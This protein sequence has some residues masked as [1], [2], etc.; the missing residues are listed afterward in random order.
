VVIQRSSSTQTVRLI[1]D[2]LGDDA[3]CREAAVARLAIVGDRAVDRLLAALPDAPAPGRVAILRVLEAIASPR[4]LPAITP[5]LAAHDDAVAVAAAGAMR[6]HLKADDDR[7]ATSALEALTDLVLAA[8][9]S[10]PPRLAALDALSEMDAD[11]LRPIRDRLRVD[12]SP[13]VRRLA[14]WT[15]ADEP[16]AENAAARLEAAARGELPDDGE[17]LRALVASAGAAVA[18]ST[19]LDLVKTLRAREQ[20]TADEDTRRRWAATR[21]AAHQALAERHSRL[22]VYDLRETLESAGPGLPV[23]FLA[24]VTEIGD[25]SC[26]ESIAAAWQQVQEP[27]VREQLVAA[28]KE[29]LTREKLTRRHAAVRRVLERRPEAGRALLTSG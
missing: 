22:A 11:T 23:G 20:Q 7:V 5:W 24:A 12:P 27:W 18:L 9:R 4:L 14:G 8:T 21:A 1:A 13:R 10:D 2:L 6:P 16:S 26:L 15:E 29:I 17:A 25:A 19:L 28:F 3:V